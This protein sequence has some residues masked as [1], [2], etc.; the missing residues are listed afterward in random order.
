MNISRIDNAD[1]KEI[2]EAMDAWRSAQDY[3]ESVFDP[4]LVDYAI[5]QL[6]AAKRRYM[7]MLGRQKAV[8]QGK[9]SEQL[10]LE[11]GQR[12]KLAGYAN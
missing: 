4:E 11:S 8:L 5:Y 3:F 2:L 10:P 12:L 1:N 9:P 7:Y 6:E